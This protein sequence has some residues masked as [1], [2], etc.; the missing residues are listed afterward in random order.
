[1]TAA[2]VAVAGLMVL[3]ISLRTPA[4]GNG[5]LRGKVTLDGRPL[6]GATIDFRTEERSAVINRLFYVA[7]TDADGH[8]EAKDLRPNLVYTVAVRRPGDKAP[9]QKPGGGPPTVRVA[10]GVRHFDIELASQ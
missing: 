4:T 2:I 6:A 7:R 8:Y 10:P 3:I 5:T 9:L 1:L